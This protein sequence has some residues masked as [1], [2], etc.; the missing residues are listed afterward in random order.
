ME[1]SIWLMPSWM[2]ISMI[3]L[4]VLIVILGTIIYIEMFGIPFGISYTL[5]SNSPTT[6]G[7][8][9]Q[10]QSSPLST[11]TITYNGSS[12]ASSTNGTLPNSA[13]ETLSSGVFTTSPM[14]WSDG[15]AVF[16]INRVMLRENQLS[17]TLTVQIGDSPTCVPLNLR[18]IADESGNLQKPDTR[19]FALPKSGDCNGAPDAIYP[20]QIVTF[21]ITPVNFP[22]LFTTNSDSDKF[23]EI[24][25]TANGELRIELPGTSG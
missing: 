4:S 6:S 23:F 14:S 11:S 19:D 17:F 21:T 12:A 20:N 2:K 22:L 10:S 7:P 16:S 1:G 9:H 8:S 3:S 24:V 18:L 5:I 15:G 25:N 13:D